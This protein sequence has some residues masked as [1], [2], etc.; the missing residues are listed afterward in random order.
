MNNPDNETSL[1]H[2]TENVW[3]RKVSINKKGHMDIVNIC[4]QL[5]DKSFVTL[6]VLYF[7]D[8]VYH[9]GKESIGKIDDISFLNYIEKLTGINKSKPRADINKSD[10]VKS[11][12]SFEEVGETYKK[13]NSIKQ[14]AKA[15]GLSEEKT[16]KILITEG[17]YTSEKHKEIKE[18]LDQGKTI[19]EI[20]EQL[21]MSQKQIRVFLPY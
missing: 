12:V 6:G 14:T 15:V 4:L 2:F 3:L 1:Q 18:L 5:E 9:A 11:D 7:Q 21:K 16:K 8:G 20:A 13:T 17:L 19:N 10:S